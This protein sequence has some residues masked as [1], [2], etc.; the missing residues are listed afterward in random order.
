MKKVYNLGD[1]FFLAI[2]FMSF[3][4]GSVLQLLGIDDIGW[5]ITSRNL[6]VNAALCLLFSV[7]LSL[8]DIARNQIK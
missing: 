6:I 4:V 1:D 5:G 8:Y 2:A 7:A 3:V